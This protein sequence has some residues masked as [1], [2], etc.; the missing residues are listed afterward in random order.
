MGVKVYGVDKVLRNLN[1]ELKQIK[2][3]SAVRLES[4]A[5]LVKN[6]SLK[7]TPIKSGNLRGSCYVD[8]VVETQDGMYVEIGYTASYAPYVHEMP[9]TYRF[10]APGT[11][12]KFLERALLETKGDIIKYLK[13]KIV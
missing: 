5:L 10:T 8:P 1:K 9:E 7:K 2:Q 3:V 11:G 6:R 4:C 12:P 13:G